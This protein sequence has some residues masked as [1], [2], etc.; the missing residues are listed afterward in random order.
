M[1][2]NSI[3]HEYH[4]AGKFGLRGEK[5]SKRRKPTPEEM[6]R[7]N[8]RNK[9]RRL[10]HVITANFYPNDVWVTLKYPAGTRKNHEEVQKDWEKFLRRLRKDYRKRGEELKFVARIEVGKQGGAHI[11]MLLNRIAWV[12]LLIQ[13]DWV[14]DLVHIAPCYAENDMRRLAEYLAKPLPQEEETKEGSQLS[15]LEEE[16]R[17]EYAKYT[18]SRNLVRPEPEVKRYSRRSVRKLIEQ[19]P[20]A[21]EGFYIDKTSIRKGVNQYTGYSYLYYTEIRLNPIMRRI[22]QQDDFHPITRRRG[23]GEAIHGD[24]EDNRTADCCGSIRP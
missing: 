1:G 22:R 8:Q 16:E 24:R 10:W 12:E 2:I 5:R 6:R 19:G 7:V 11:H 15:F 20:K 14:C 3:D 4:Y 21:R 18:S 13:K 9:E 17:Q 23:C